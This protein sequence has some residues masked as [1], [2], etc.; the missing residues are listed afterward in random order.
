MLFIFS[1][2][3]FY[4]TYV[5]Q[6]IA[7]HPPPDEILNNPKFWPFFKDAIGALDGSHIHTSPLPQNGHRT[8]IAKAL[9]PKTAYLAVTSL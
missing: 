1:S 5:C 9:S 4:T 3:P 8:E 7:N 6:P 2:P